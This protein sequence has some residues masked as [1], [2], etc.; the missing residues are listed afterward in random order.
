MKMKKKKLVNIFENPNEDNVGNLPNN[1]YNQG[2]LKMK[3]LRMKL[4]R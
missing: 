1:H 2:K 4:I 3:L